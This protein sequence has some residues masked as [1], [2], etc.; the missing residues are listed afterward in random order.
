MI[1][2]PF[3]GS[4]FSWDFYPQQNENRKMAAF[5][6][7][8]KTTVESLPQLL[9]N[10]YNDHFGFRNTFI[11][12][13][14]KMEK[15][16]FNRG[17]SKVVKG[18]TPGWFFYKKAGTIADFVGN[19]Q[20]SQEELGIWKDTLE[21]RKR[22]LSERNIPYI[23][24]VCPDKPMVYPE[25]LPDITQKSRGQTRFEQIQK[26]FQKNSDFEIVYPLP[27]LLAAKDAHELYLPGDTHWNSNGGFIGYQ[28]IVE[29]LQRYFPEI[30]PVKL[31]DCVLSVVEAKGDL[32]T[33]YSTK[34]KLIEM[35]MIS[36]PAEFDMITQTPCAAYTN[37]V[38]Q[39][40]LTA[41]PPKLS[42]NPKGKGTALI[43]HDSFIGHG[44]ASLL[45]TH[46]EN[47]YLFFM[48]IET[49]DFEQLVDELNPDVVIEM[50]VE[51]SMRFI[52]GRGREAE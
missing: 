9:E 14:Q 8:Q 10:Y 16:L 37:E 33:M 36:A 30:E 20:L 25:H 19:R 26:Y 51:R 44:L 41:P 38:W 24:F 49:P 27:E 43:I 13:H 17:T 15:Q 6:S 39:E 34:A 7:I 4:F 31:E 47:T 5:P 45:P 18:K 1:S 40:K 52:P 22:Y 3:L 11:R 48:Y 28:K 21:E 32:A 2:L 42:H 29:Q 46:F 35:P 23:F 12:R 50:R